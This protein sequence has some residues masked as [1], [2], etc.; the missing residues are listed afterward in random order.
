[1]YTCWHFIEIYIPIF[2]QKKLG[3]GG[4]I[5][6]TYYNPKVWV[7]IALPPFKICN[8][9]N[10][11]DFLFKAIAKSNGHNLELWVISILIK[12]HLTQNLSFSVQLNLRLFLNTSLGFFSQSWKIKVN[13]FHC[14]IALFL[15]YSSC[16][17]CLLK[18]IRSQQT[19]QGRNLFASEI[20]DFPVC[21]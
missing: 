19:K 13:V 4:H 17:I 2:Q 21:T 5:N 7:T 9:G 12:F 6:K 3:G 10:S 20:Y 11:I 1:M 18:E 14:Q 16:V 8:I 15:G